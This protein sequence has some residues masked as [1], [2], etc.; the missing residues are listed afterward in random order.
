MRFLVA[1]SSASLSVTGVLALLYFAGVAPGFSADTIAVTLLALAAFSGLTA[2][3]SGGASAVLSRRL[4]MLS[5]AI[6]AAPE[7][8]LIV[9]PDGRVC[10]ANLLFNRLFPD[11]RATAFDRIERALCDDR[12][13]QAEFRRIRNGAMAGV[14][15]AATLCMSKLPTAGPARFRITTRPVAG[16]PGYSFCEIRDVTSRHE[17]EAAI[18][19]ERDSLSDLVDNA[20]IGFYSVDGGGRFRFVNRTLAGWLGSSPSE[21]L[22]SRARLHDFLASPPAAG[23]PAYS[24]LGQ[25]GGREERGEVVLNTCAGRAMA[26]WIAQNVGRVGPQL[27]TRSVVCDLTP[28]RV[29]KAALR[30]SERFRR[31][32]ASAPV[33]IALLDRSGRFEEANRA[34]G[35]LFGATPQS[36]KG[37]DLISL[38]NQEDRDRVAAKLVAAAEGRVDSVPVEVRPARPADKTMV[39]FVGHLGDAAGSSP[40]PSFSQAVDPGDGLTLH[41]IDVTEQ[42]NLEIQFAQSQKM[43][44]IGQLAGGVA[45]DFNNLLTAMIGFCDLLLLRSPPSD[46]SFS[47]IMQIKQNANRAASLVRQLLAFSRQQTLQPRILNITDILYELRHLIERL[48]GE[49]I[50]LEVVHGRDLGFAKVDHGQFE[51]VIINL[52]VNA[53]DAMP[54]GG[55]LTIRTANV[56]QE[57][58]LRRGHEV[59]SSGDY[60]FIEIK[61]TGI[62][63]PKE[64]LNRV[65]DPFFSTKELGSGTGLGLSTVYGIIKQ[66]GGF[67]FVNSSPG[68]GTAFAIYLPRCDPPGGAQSGRAD[69]GEVAGNDLTG[70]GTI[71]LVEDDDPVRI[72]GARALR[73]KGYKVV[74]AKSGEAALKLIRDSKQ[75]IDLLITDVVMPQM[76]GPGL[77]REV[78]T[79]HP[80]MKVIFISGYTEDAFRQRLD[81]DSGIDFLPKPFSLKQLAAKV[82]EVLASAT[83]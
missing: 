56:R 44:A 5:R 48:I 82:R 25:G 29:W 36:L 38:L 15:A 23:S 20:P 37:R 67:I 49:N 2:L 34:V 26:V 81:S 24:P 59:M 54:D 17:L 12:E 28:E 9:A 68:R 43:Q 64:N 63:I 6:D 76:D 80:E 55:T 57:Q 18:R 40:S 4:D 19:E 3:S 62:G 73:N 41:F 50:E 10:H 65:F 32:F 79:I 52:A 30:S 58:Q 71:M 83:T 27:H 22:A 13:S 16:Y 53:R 70:C 60:V 66:T 46:P 33:G 77:V 72:F 45:H 42:K 1:A 75:R 14:N 47:D 39:L 7:A 11:Q 61:D 8:L 74:E 35:Q 31:C 21:L 78:R 69:Q 51:Q